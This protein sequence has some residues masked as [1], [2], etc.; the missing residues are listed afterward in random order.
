MPKKGQDWPFAEM[1]EDER[2][3]PPARVTTY[4]GPALAA[5]GDVH[6]PTPT[7]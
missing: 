4:F 2:R 6:P 7:R 5:V 1:S 3:D